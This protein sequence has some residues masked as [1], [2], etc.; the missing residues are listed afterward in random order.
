MKDLK[1][2]QSRKRQ[3]S[4]I[5]DTVEVESNIT[6]VNFTDIISADIDYYSN[7]CHS[8]SSDKEARFFSVEPESDEGSQEIDAINYPCAGN[9]IHQ[10]VFPEEDQNFNL[11]APF[12]TPIDY[13]LA[14]FFNST[15]TSQAKIDQFFKD[16]LLKGLNLI[17]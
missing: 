3:F 4:N 1:E 16:N 13:R 5:S 7:S 12:H 11:F 8:E 2:P 14:R 6:E 15:K 9:P 17:H 10:Y